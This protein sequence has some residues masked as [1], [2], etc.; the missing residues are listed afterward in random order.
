MYISLSILNKQERR[1]AMLRA[2]EKRNNSN[3]FGARNISD[4]KKKDM[5]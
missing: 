4:E 1:E 2:A 3:A 5:A